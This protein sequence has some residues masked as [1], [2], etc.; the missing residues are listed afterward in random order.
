MRRDQQITTVVETHIYELSLELM[1]DQG[2][3]SMSSYI[4]KLMVENLIKE[5]RL[6]GV[7]LVDILM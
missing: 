7:S 3:T 5:G 2:V 4:R 1:K 6:T